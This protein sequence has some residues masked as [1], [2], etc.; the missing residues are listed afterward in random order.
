VSL[1]LSAKI[2][3]KSERYYHE[4]LIVRESSPIVVPNQANTSA[5]RGLADMHKAVSGPET[6]A[7]L[8]RSSAEV[9]KKRTNAGARNP[10][11]ATTTSTTTSTGTSTGSS[12][13][14][15]R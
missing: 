1:S 11:Q 9:K 7:Q 12:T 3:I 6:R 15:N 10:V 4:Q 2:R 8:R 13:D 5:N 14:A